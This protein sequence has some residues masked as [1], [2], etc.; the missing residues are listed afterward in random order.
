MPSDLNPLDI[1]HVMKEDILIDNNACCSFKVDRSTMRI[2]Y[3]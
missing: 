2:F 3:C 1:V